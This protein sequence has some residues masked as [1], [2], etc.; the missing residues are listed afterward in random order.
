MIF[1]LKKIFF[2]H[3]PVSKEDLQHNFIILT[4]HGL[5]TLAE[6]YLND[7]LLGLTDNMFTRYRFD[8]KPYLVAVSAFFNEH[9]NLKRINL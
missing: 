6:I 4:F 8:I 9:F 2:S 7:Q 3:F 5:D 1:K